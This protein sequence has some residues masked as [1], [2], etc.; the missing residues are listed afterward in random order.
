MLLSDGAKLMMAQNTNTSSLL[1]VVHQQK[2]H[3]RV[4]PVATLYGLQTP[5]RIVQGMQGLVA[6]MQ[7]LAEIYGM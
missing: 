6:C 3:R 2:S 7:V 5:N 1:D 4:R